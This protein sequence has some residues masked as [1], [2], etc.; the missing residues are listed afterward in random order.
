M[1]R[2]LLAC[3]VVAAGVSASAQ[4]PVVPP[5]PVPPS[6]TTLRDLEIPLVVEGCIQGKRLKVDQIA[7]RRL[8]GLVETNEFVLDASKELMRH[9]ESEH[10]GHQDQIEGVVVI[11]GGRQQRG[12][13]TTRDLGDKTRITSSG[14]RDTGEDNERP[15]SSM[16]RLKVKA[17][18]HLD[19]KC[20]TMG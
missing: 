4:R 16:Y 11:P 20:S 1:R 6:N 17:L 19:E 5:S 15:R 12:N 8:A 3:L 13:V 7:I 18:T 14:R 9:I 10:N 2:I